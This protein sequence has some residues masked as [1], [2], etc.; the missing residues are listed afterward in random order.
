MVAEQGAGK[1]E[2]DI[3]VVINPHTRVKSRAWLNKEY[4]RLILKETRKMYTSVIIKESSVN[5]Q[6]KEKLQE[7]LR[8]TLQYAVKNQNKKIGKNLKTYAQAVGVKVSQ[9]EKNDTTREQMKNNNN[10]QSKNRN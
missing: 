3:N 7:F 9:I 2:K 8:P 1:L 5:N 6:Y 10:N 4:P